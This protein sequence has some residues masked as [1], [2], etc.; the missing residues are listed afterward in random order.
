MSLSQSSAPEP[1]GFGKLDLERYREAAVRISK[2]RTAGSS[3]IQS[4]QNQLKELWEATVGNLFP[5]NACS[6]MSLFQHRIDLGKLGT[7]PAEWPNGFGSQLQDASFTEQA[8]SQ[9][10]LQRDFA[11]GL[12]GP[13]PSSYP[14]SD[15]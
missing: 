15:C 13:N 14:P 12:Q 2:Q 4:L 11:I 5:S 1:F 6:A 8:L 7:K 9:L 3:S 10:I